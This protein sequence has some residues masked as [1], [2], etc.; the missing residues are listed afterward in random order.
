MSHLSITPKL[1]Y[2]SLKLKNCMC[3]LCMFSQIQSHLQRS[4][5][6][7]FVRISQSDCFIVKVIYFYCVDFGNDM[8]SIH[9]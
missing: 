1:L 5:L 6:G 3:K 8:A 7:L 4:L 9:I 2:E